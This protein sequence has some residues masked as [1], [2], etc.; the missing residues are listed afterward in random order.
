MFLGTLFEGESLLLAAGYAAHRGLLDWRLV[1]VVAIAGAT[2][3]DQLAFQLGRWKGRALITKVPLLARN[4]QRMCDLLGRYDALCVMGVRFLYGLR[5]AGPII[6]GMSNL[7]VWRFAIL[8]LTGA[9]MWAL[10]VTGVGYVFGVAIHTL[11]EHV[12]KI[13]AFVLVGIVVGGAF[14]ALFRTWR[15][16][17]SS[18]VDN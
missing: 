15:T 6:I 16:R 2:V 11:L 18:D 1:V 4:E 12:E 10:I 7:S 13:E 17:Q 5:I 14:V 3:G 8:N 9:V